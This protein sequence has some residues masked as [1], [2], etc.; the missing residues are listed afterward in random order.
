MRRESYARLKNLALPLYSSKSKGPSSKPAFKATV[1]VGGNTFES[2]AYFKT[3]K[4]ADHVAA[5]AALMSMYPDGVQ[6]VSLFEN[7]VLL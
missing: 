2:P 5:K 7:F 6:V 3:V 1:I 4:E